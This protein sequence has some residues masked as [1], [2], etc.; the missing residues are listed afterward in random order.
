M[1]TGVVQSSTRTL[2]TL[3]AITTLAACGHTAA[4]TEEVNVSLDVE[5]ELDTRPQEL[6]PRAWQLYEEGKLFSA[7][8]ELKAFLKIN[9]NHLEASVLLA[10]M[11]EET[12]DVGEAGSAW[13][14]VEALLVYQGKLEP[15]LL[16]PSLFSGA[17]RYLRLQKPARARLFYDELWRRFPASSWSQHTQLEVVEAAVARGR[18]G[19][20]SR[21]CS[22]ML[23]QGAQESC[24]TRCK[25]LIKVAARML[26]MGPDP[27]DGAPRW[28]WL[29][30]SP[31]GNTLN[32]AWAGKNG[33]F[34]AVGAGG[35]T[36]HRPAGAGAKFALIQSG[37]RWDLRA[38]HGTS[39]ENLFAVGD[40]GIV[41]KYDGKAWRTL[42]TADPVNPDLSGVYSSSPGQLAAVSLSGAILHY[43]GGK[44][45]N[46][47]AT[48]QPLYGIWGDGKGKLFAVGKG[49]LML[50][51]QGG[52]WETTKSDS[53][54]D[55]WGI[56]GNGDGNMT[57]VGSN[58]TVMALSAD[59]KTKEAV[60][61]LTGFRDVWGL[62][63]GQSWAVGIRG[64]IIHQGKRDGPWANQRTGVSI[65]LLGVAGSNVRDMVAVGQGGTLLT[66]GRKGNWKVTGGGS[67]ERLVAVVSDP[68]SGQ[69]G[70]M[71]V[72]EKGSLLL[73]GDKGWKRFN[74]LPR[75]RY[76]ALCA[77]GGRFGAVGDRGLFMLYENKKW[78]RIKSGTS[79]DLMALDGCD[80]GGL[81]AVGTRGTVVRYMNGKTKVER[82][83]T[84][85]TLYGVWAGSAKNIWAVGGRGVTVHYDG[86]KW[87]ELD[88]GQIN[89]L[90]AVAMAGKQLMAVGQGGI[91]L[92]LEGNRWKPFES[93]TAQTLVALWGDPRGR[94]VALSRQGGIVHH[95]GEK[96][97]VH[98]SPAPCLSNLVHHPNLGLLAVGCN[99]SIIRL[100]LEELK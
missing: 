53:Y 73:H 51:Y 57:A 54:E 60:A 99:Q 20:V 28:R 98:A 21:I 47:Q 76:R 30:P 80:K 44:W 58:R 83:P 19:N 79:E 66:R 42:R 18:W 2:L 84:G 96:W 43:A 8:A 65:D 64:N 40:A 85:H 61:G 4:V 88:T 87:L 7:E 37:T 49:G 36:L 91:V 72:G 32:D 46:H 15:F 12:G 81:V 71:A 93:P 33:E 67:T 35:T 74:L 52:K 41:L 23:R 3:L 68:G 13:A 75:G 62:G 27:T 39:R 56:W 25:Y 1:R 10:Y 24:V 82:T 90:R 14:D 95:D 100:P 59:G 94:V 11:Q 31:Q 77:G 55:L 29:H 5:M 16:Q 63:D 97:V 26:D 6:L 38:I 48:T 92:N 70:I 17:R 86:E 50:S 45:T 22:D 69:E 78:R 9:P 34:F 89:D